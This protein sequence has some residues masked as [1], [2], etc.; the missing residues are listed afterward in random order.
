MFT[1]YT[2]AKSTAA[3]ETAY[4]LCSKNNQLLL[5]RLDDNYK[6]ELKGIFL[7]V[8]GLLFFCFADGLYSGYNEKTGVGDREKQSGSINS[9]QKR[10]TAQE[11]PLPN[12]RK[13]R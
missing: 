13:R 8:W 10:C 3:S 7:F 9:H 12:S 1:S 6:V 5:A 11:E 4:L 2:R